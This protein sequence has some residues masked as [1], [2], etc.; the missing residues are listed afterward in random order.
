MS[1]LIREENI[2][3]RYY[4]KLKNKYPNDVLAM[5]WEGWYE[6]ELID[7]SLDPKHKGKHL[8]PFYGEFD[9]IRFSRI[10]KNGK[11]VD[12]LLYGY[13]VKGVNGDETKGWRY[14][15][16]GEGLDQ[17]AVLLMQ[18]VDYSF[19]VT[20][21]PERRDYDEILI[22]LRDKYI[23]QVGLIF[24]E[25]DGAFTETDQRPRNGTDMQKK[26]DMVVGLQTSGKCKKGSLIPQLWGRTTSRFYQTQKV[27]KEKTDD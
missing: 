9:I 26:I 17:A 18:N 20:P 10:V 13:E 7:K 23:P 4:M 16:L 8:T 15:R 1:E 12:L 14:P 21:R 27:I 24:A 5:N 25:I 11:A 6:K 19:L 2:Q 22:Q 3:K